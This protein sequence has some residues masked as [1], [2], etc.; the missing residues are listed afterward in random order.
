VGYRGKTTERQRARELRADAW[1]LQEIATE[2]H[3]SR[4]SVSV[5]VRDVVFDPKPRQ[6]PVFR[7][8]SSLHL[9]KLAE[10]EA[11]DAWGADRLGSLDDLAFLAAGTALYAGEGAKTDHSVNF[12]NT[13]PEMIRFFCVW[14]RRFFTI[15]EA[16]LRVRVYLHEGLDIAATHAYW[17][18]ITGV[19]QSQFR[20]PYRAPA[21]GTRRLNKH[22]HGCVYVIY[23][24]SLT[25]RRIMGL[26][27]ALLTSKAQS[28]VA[29]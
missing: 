21:D 10:I 14:L 26:I 3:V 18:Q 29:Q 17:S 6:R 2:L 9:R 12:A 27:R 7:N 20:K 13:D 22:E 28:G 11:A 5:W 4:S 25:H 15:D 19:P 23:S 24:C 1:T 16:R 8:P